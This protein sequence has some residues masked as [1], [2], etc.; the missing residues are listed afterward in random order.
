[1]LAHPPVYL[2]DPGAVKLARASRMP[3]PHNPTG[4]RRQ[5]SG[6]PVDRPRAAG[7]RSPH[8]RRACRCGC[9]PFK[10]RPDAQDRLVSRPRWP[11]IPR[12]W[13]DVRANTLPGHGPSRWPGSSPRGRRLHIRQCWAA[14]ARRPR[15]RRRPRSRAFTSNAEPTAGTYGALANCSTGNRRNRWCIAV[16]PTTT[17]S[18]TC[19]AAA[20]RAHNSPAASFSASTTSS[21]S[22]AACAG[23]SEA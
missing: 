2:H 22:R 23:P 13:C 18:A 21:W 11:G 7:A 17:A 3:E 6:T 8:S 19:P 4:V 10:G 12:Y 20:A 5:S 9:A 1:M 14:G 16:L 15:A